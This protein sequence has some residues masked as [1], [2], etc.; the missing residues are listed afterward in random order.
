MPVAREALPVPSTLTDSAICVSA[1][2]RSALA[3]RVDIAWTFK[4]IA[5]TKS[6]LGERLAERG[7]ASPVLL[8]RPDRQTDAT[9]EQRH[10]GVQVL[11]EYTAAAHS[12]EHGRRVG[13]AHQDEIRIAGEN[14]DPGK[15]PQLRVEAP[16]LVDD[17]LRLRVE[18]VVMREDTLGD[19][20]GQRVDV[21]GR[22]H[23]VELADPLRPSHRVAQAYPGE[24]EL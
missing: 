20:V 3:A 9:V 12:F 23:L 13:N 15:L 19:H 10:A 5:Y 16:A 21:V 14:R 24:A 6:A 11:D 17:L 7:E 8:R 18:H 4:R 1:V 22:T 2:L